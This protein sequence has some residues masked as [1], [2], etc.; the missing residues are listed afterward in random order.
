MVSWHYRPTASAAVIFASQLSR[1]SRFLAIATALLLSLA[2]AARARPQAVPAHVVAPT[3]GATVVGATACAACHQRMHETWK[4]G[5]HSRM[6]QPA[7]NA[8]VIGDF[9]KGRVTLRGGRYRFRVAN[10]RFFITESY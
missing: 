9:S 10:R 8:S 4:S 1:L 6:V 3:A 2:W 7:T 5:R